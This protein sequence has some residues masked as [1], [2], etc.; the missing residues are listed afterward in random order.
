LRTISRRKTSGA[1]G[2]IHGQLRGYFDTFRDTFFLTGLP[3]SGFIVILKAHVPAFRPLIPAP[4]ARQIFS[5]LAETE[6]E[7]F[8]PFDTT[9]PARFAKD[10]VARTFETTIDGTVVVGDS[11]PDGAAVVGRVKNPSEQP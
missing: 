5:D 3:F 11:E 2:H 1:F 9:I 8:A 4:D 7:S 10:E 6:M